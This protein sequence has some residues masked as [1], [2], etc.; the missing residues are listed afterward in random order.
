MQAQ[1]ILEKI[2]KRFMHQ[3]RPLSGFIAIQGCFFISITIS[4]GISAVEFKLAPESRRAELRGRPSRAPG[5]A[6]TS[7]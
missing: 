2:L 6:Q 5:Q 4:A 7:G 1:R 3:G